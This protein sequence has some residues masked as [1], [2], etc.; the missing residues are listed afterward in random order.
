MKNKQIVTR[1]ADDNKKSLVT[2]LQETEIPALSP[3]E[4]LVRNLYVPMHGSFWLASHP[5]AIHPR[6]DEFLENGS[7]VFGNGGVAQVIDSREDEREVQIGDYVNVFGHLP[8]YNYDCYGCKVLHRYTE[9]DYSSGGILGHGKGAPDGTYAEYTVLPRYAYDVCYRENEK[10]SKEDLLPYM[11]GFLFADVRNAL[12]RHPDAL[13]TR[14]LFLVGAGYSGLIA[15]YIFHRTSPESQIFAI[16]VSEERLERLREIAPDSIRTYKIPEQVATQLDSSEPKLGFRHELAE[17]INEIASEADKFFNGKG[18]NLL[19]D[20]SSGNS[21][22]LWDNKQILSPT[23]IAIPFGFGSEYVLLTKELIQHS[24]L[25]IL[26]SR[27]VGNIRNRKETLHLIRSGGSRFINEFL[28]SESMELSGIDSAM[29]FI[30]NMHN[31][32]RPLYEIDHAYIAFEG[33]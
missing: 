21:A 8:C 13:R 25:N 27:G 14:R 20:S 23:T 11:F 10:P 32:P 22:P 18:I 30:Q 6:K 26:M 1:W 24:G 5:D 4:I 2:E 31:P 16:D 29:G 19:F 7:F 3:G 28:V 17:T 12:T 15:A 33:K 9:C